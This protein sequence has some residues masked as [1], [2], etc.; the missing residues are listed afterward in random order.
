MSF[1][2]VEG[3]FA[4]LLLSFSS[5]REENAVPFSMDHVLLRMSPKV[6]DEVVVRCGVGLLTD[7]SLFCSTQL[8]S[9]VGQRCLH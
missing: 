6:G 8:A 4:S 5:Q 7:F 9:Y 3:F 1:V 2:S